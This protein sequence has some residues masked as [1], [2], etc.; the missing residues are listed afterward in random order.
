[1]RA[2]VPHVPAA[3]WDRQWSEADVADAQPPLRVAARWLQEL[4]SPPRPAPRPAVAATPAPPPPPTPPPEPATDPGLW[5]VREQEELDVYRRFLRDGWWPRRGPLAG[6]YGSG[7]ERGPGRGDAELAASLVGRPLP[8]TDFPTA[9]G[10]RLDLASLRGKRVLLVV[11]RGFTSQICPYCYAQTTELMRDT[12]RWAELECEVVVQYPGTRSRLQAFVE[13]CTREFA[14]QPLPYHLVY[15]PDL[16]LA[17]GLGL[18]GNLARPASFVLDR[19][20][21][22]RHAYVAESEINIADRPSVATL[23]DLVARTD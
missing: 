17:K 6:R 11:M 22:V 8:V 5:T 23:R 15:D 4:C 12:E 18:Q 3:P 2:V 19:S 20:G 10:T 9:Q 7:G 21:I 16:E 1:V 14:G 13:A